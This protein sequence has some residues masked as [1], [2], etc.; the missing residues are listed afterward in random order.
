MKV[1]QIDG[2]TVARL[3]ADYSG[4]EEEHLN[5][6]QQELFDLVDKGEQ[7]LLVLDFSDTEF[8]SS[9]FIE[10]V[11]RVWNRINRRSGKLALASLQPFCLDVLKTAKLDTLWKIY[12][13]SAQAVAGLQGQ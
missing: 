9:T 12:P 5:Q 13:T 8:F 3:D 7:P 4:L 6:T 1:E 11:F 2:V 10:V